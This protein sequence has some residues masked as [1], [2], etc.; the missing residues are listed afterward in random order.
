MCSHQV[1]K[2]FP[3]GSQS[4]PQVLNVFSNTFPITTLFFITY[5]FGHGSTS[6]YIT[7]KRGVG[8]DMTKHAF[9]LGNRSIFLGFY[10]VECPMFQ[11]Y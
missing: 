10:V 3:S 6:M 7:C 5:S 2:V 1:P 4:V 9:I 8:E 11:K